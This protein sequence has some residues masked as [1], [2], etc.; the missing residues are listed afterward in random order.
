[1][2]NYKWHQDKGF[3]FSLIIIEKG[4]SSSSTYIFSYQKKILCHNGVE[5]L[6]ILTLNLTQKASKS[7]DMFEATYINFSISTVSQNSIIK[8]IECYDIF[9]QQ[10]KG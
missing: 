8:K 4:N 2:Y 9:Y 6:K 1:M 10:L 3:L 5:V 7:V